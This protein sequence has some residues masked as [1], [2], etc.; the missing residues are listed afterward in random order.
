MNTP[1]AI[2]PPHT[3]IHALDFMEE[4]ELI[5]AMESL[6]YPGAKP[7]SIKLVIANC[8]AQVM[9]PMTKPFHITPMQVKQKRQN[10]GGFEYKWRDVV[11]PGIELYRIKASRT[12]TYAGM[13]E[14][15]WG[16]AVKLELGGEEKTEWDEQARAKVAKGNW[17][18]L[19]IEV[20]EWCEFIVYR[21][22]QNTRYPFRSGR[23][24]WEETYATA[25]RETSLPNEMW[26]KRK[27]GQLEK[28][29]EA[30]A[31]RRAFPEIGAAPILEEMEG[32]VLDDSNIV[33]GAVTGRT[34]EQTTGPT[35]TGG[36]ANTSQPSQTETGAAAGAAADTG[37]KPEDDKLLSDGAKKT[38]RDALKRAG[39]TEPDLEA[40]G[41]G[42]VDEMPFSKFND[43]MAWA[44]KPAATAK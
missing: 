17:P 22:V 19:S 36:A 24:Y 43:A 29:A 9:D 33:E 32:K 25:G 16:P 12:G 7:E 28:C 23:V 13:D 27:R 40:A 42:K 30:L 37:K 41:L 1:L 34:V 2:R 8:R 35:A 11:M 26:K 5:S 31:L 21:I 14:A 6:L 39:K 18:K 3:G 15:L 20:P 44:R 38:L 4:G 10:G